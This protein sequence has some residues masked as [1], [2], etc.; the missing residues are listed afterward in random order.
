MKAKNNFVLRCELLK[1]VVKIIAIGR[2]GVLDSMA[3]LSLIPYGKPSRNM[4]TRLIKV[5]TEWSWFLAV[6][7]SDLSAPLEKNSSMI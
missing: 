3:R 1:E 4:N 2:I 5:T 6:Y 7:V